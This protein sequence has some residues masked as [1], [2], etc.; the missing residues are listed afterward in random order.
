MLKSSMTPKKDA[1]RYPWNAPKALKNSFTKVRAYS[2]EQKFICGVVQWI[3]GEV[4][5]FDE[6]LSD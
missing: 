3:S 4:E 1:M 6:I 5:A 2:F